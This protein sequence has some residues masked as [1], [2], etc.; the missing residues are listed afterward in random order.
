MNENE[1]L[2]LNNYYLGLFILKIIK[3]LQMTENYKI[4]IIGAGI[5]GCTAALKLSEAGHICTLFEK[6]KDNQPSKVIKRF[7]Y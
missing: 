5:F 6:Q 7:R 1:E 4:A 3:F 2:A